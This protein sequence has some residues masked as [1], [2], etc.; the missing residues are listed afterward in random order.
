M[1]EKREVETRAMKQIYYTQCPIGYGLGASNGFQI[2]RLSPGYPVS[3]DFRHLGLRA[4]VAG[5][6][7]LAPPTLRYRRGEDGVAEVAWLTPRSNEY[8]TE[9]GLWGRPGGHFAHGLQLDD[10]EMKAIRD[11]PAGLYDQP[12]WTRTDR[13]PSRGQAPESRELKI[14]ALRRAPTFGQVAPLA[15]GEDRERLAMLLTALASAAVMGGPS[16]SSMSRTGLP[17]GSPC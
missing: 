17:I 10:A 7:T 9:R 6:R 12:F 15:A 5:T 11:W 8:E 4:F 2:K 3:G 14:E 16:I 1:E 13:E